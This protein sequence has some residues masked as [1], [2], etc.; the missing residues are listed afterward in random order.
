MNKK[1]YI[2]IILLFIVTTITLFFIIN[3]NKKVQVFKYSNNTTQDYKIP[4]LLYH[5]ILKDNEIN[6]IFKNNGAVI[7]L[8]NFKE[9]MKYLYDN[10][11]TTINLDELYN[12]KIGQLKAT[13]KMVVITFD[14]GYYSNYHYAYPILKKYNFKACEF[15]TTNKLYKDVNSFNS[16][17]LQKLTLDNINEMKDVFQ[18]G[19]HTHNMHYIKNNKAALEIE[20]EDLINKDIKKFKSILDTP[21]IA[22]PFGKYN[23]DNIHSILKNNNFK[24]GFTVKDGYI[25]PYTDILFM[26]RFIIF[27]TYDINK[28]KEIV[29]IK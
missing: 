5:H 8:N 14:D 28:F 23:K 24:M 27:P 20:S 9:Q 25:T 17:I 4:V 2:L 7:S 19:C 29:T 13:D 18:F 3:K 10:N 1:K 15:I 16:T 12:I 22:Y 6:G 21:Y 11:Y 26:N